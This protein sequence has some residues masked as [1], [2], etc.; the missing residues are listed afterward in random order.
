M[1][2]IKIF[3]SFGK[4]FAV[5]V[6]LALSVKAMAAEAI[7]T[8]PVSIISTT[9]AVRYYT[10]RVTKWDDGSDVIIVVLPRDSFITKN[11]VFNK[12][13]LSTSQFFDSLTLNSTLQKRHTVRFAASQQEMLYLVN[14]L[15][16]SLGYIVESMVSSLPEGVHVLK[17]YE[18]GLK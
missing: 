14:S 6:M 10:G 8:V 11:F 1:K 12:L 3:R 9:D 18:S 7:T 2:V 15:T 17:I 5:A 4:R 13:G 16:G